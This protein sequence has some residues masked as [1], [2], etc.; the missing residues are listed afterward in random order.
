MSESAE[1]KTWEPL[2]LLERRVLGVLVE[3][4]KTTPEAY[5]M[6]L[7]GL[8][9]GSNQKSNRD[10]VMN[11][12]DDA[13]EQTLAGLQ[14][15]G[16]IIRITG[17][18]VDRFKHQMYA[19]WEVEKVELAILAEL[20]LRGPQTEGE[21]RGRAA[22]MEPIE[23]VA[24]LR[25]HL[26]PLVQRKLVVLLGPEG[27][28]GTLITHGFHAPAELARLH[29]AA[30]TEDAAP[31]TAAPSAGAVESRSELAEL[32]R[33]LDE[34]KETVRRLEANL[35]DLQAKLGGI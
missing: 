32:R 9:T 4:A 7:N 18:R 15:K 33:E 19:V 6:S 35:S 20:L 34:L 30:P 16:L 26:T 13:V 11:L 10:P 14:K 17:G 5:P 1:T 24:A 2:G 23:D 31:R 27:R 12:T 25:T 28:R 3:K 21:L 29:A 22:R 8:T